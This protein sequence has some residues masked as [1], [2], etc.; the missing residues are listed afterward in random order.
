MLISRQAINILLGLG[1]VLGIVACFLPWRGNDITTLSGFNGEMGNPGIWA[2]VL[3]GLRGII[4]FLPFKRTR[5]AG[6]LAS[7]GL[8]FFTLNQIK[9]GIRLENAGPQ[10]GIFLLL[11]AAMILLFLYWTKKKSV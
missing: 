6:I 5:Q 7:L 9:I 11:I 4:H 1:L 10:M 8:L 2:I 3:L